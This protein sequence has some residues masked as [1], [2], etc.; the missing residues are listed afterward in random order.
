MKYHRHRERLCTRR[1]MASEQTARLAEKDRERDKLV[2]AIFEEIR[3]AARSPIAA[4]A[5]S[6]RKLRLVTDTYKGLQWETVA[7]ETGK[8]TGNSG[9]ASDTAKHAALL[10]PGISALEQ[11]LHLPSGSLT[12]TGKTEGS[13]EKRHYELAVAGKTAPDGTLRIIWVG[14]NK[15][16]SLCTCEKTALTSAVPVTD[17]GSNV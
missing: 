14:L 2:T 9:K 5:E 1:V 6:G 17:T 7:E 8:E 15:N 16:G 4:R 12:F 3:Q 13:G 10:A 11:F